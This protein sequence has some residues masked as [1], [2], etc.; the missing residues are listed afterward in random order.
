MEA[1][2]V[3]SV[4]SDF[5]DVFTTTPGAGFVAI[6]EGIRD[7]A[8]MFANAATF[9]QIDSL[10]NYVN[11]V[12]EQGGG[13]YQVANVSMHVGAYSLEAASVLYVWGAF[14]PTYGVGVGPGAAVSEG[15]TGIHIIYGAAEPGGAMVWNHA[16]GGGLCEGGWVIGASQSVVEGMWFTVEGIPIISATGVTSMELGVGNCFVTAVVAYGRGWVR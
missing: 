3:P 15:G 11:S 6:G 1:R 16:V 5:W 7:G 10:N 2:D 13:L 12:V 4:V 14:L 9:H 8:A